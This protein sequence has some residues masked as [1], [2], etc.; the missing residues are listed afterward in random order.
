MTGAEGWI[1][2]ELIATIFLTV[3]VPNLVLFLVV[4]VTIK[5]KLDF[6][7]TRTEQIAEDIKTIAEHSIR[8][9]VLQNRVGGID[10]DIR[11]LRRDLRT[12][13]ER[14]NRVATGGPE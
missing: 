13:T 4:F 11:E 7:T 10:E 9:E 12:I 3:G 14:V 2:F 6:W 1:G 5:N 8:L